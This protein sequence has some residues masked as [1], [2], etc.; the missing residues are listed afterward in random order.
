MSDVCPHDAQSA[1]A[2]FDLLK[3]QRMHSSIKKTIESNEETCQSSICSAAG[4]AAVPSE[5]GS[6]QTN[7]FVCPCK[8]FPVHPR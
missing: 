7:C 3:E 4:S 8:K 2:M 1:D 5:A 6:S